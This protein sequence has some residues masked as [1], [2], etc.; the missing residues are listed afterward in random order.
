[1]EPL[2]VKSVKILVEVFQEKA[3]TGK[4]L[5]AF[6]YGRNGIHGNVGTNFHI[7]SM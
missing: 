3:K 5:E 1:M 6:R 2:I 7:L 4:S